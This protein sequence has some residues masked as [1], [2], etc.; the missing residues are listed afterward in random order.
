M[1]MLTCV[2]LLI[3]CAPLSAAI[4]SQPLSPTRED[5]E[6]VDKAIIG[7]LIEIRSA[8]IAMN[9]HL[10]PQEQAFA[11]EVVTDQLKLN[12]ELTDMARMKS[13][14]APDELP[15]EEQAKLV[16][17]SKQDDQDF[18]ENFLKIM[19]RRQKASVELF[20]DEQGASRDADLKPFV[21]R[22]LPQ[23]KLHLEAARQLAARY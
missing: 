3:A 11:H 22:T 17:M 21:A 8:E 14:P 15:A 5:I 10:T 7:G 23:L 12:K 1:S 6:F 4:A 13:I 19:I 18:N 20:D 16:A 9:R 2:R